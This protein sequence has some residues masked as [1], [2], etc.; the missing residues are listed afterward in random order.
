[1]E[2]KKILLPRTRFYNATDENLNIGLGLNESQILL[3]EGERNIVLDIDEIFNKERNDSNKYKIYGKIKMVF[4]N[5]YSGTTT[6]EPLLKFLYLTDSSNGYIPYNEFAF[7][8]NDVVREVNTNTEI[9]SLDDY[10]PII[11]LKGYDGHTT[12]TTI[13]APYKN[14]NIY[15]S[16]VFDQDNEYPLTYTL[17]GDTGGNKTFNFISSD[18]IPFRVV[19]NNKTF[20]LT[21]PVEHGMNVGEYV[22]I[23][24]TPLYI[25]SV[26]D[27]KYNSEK[28]VINI[29]ENDVPS[30]FNFNEVVFGKRCIDIDNRDIT[31]SKYY[32][33]KHKILTET[34][35]YIL[36]KIGFESP[37]WKDEKKILFENVLGENDIIVEKNRMESLIYDFKEPFILSGITNNLGY[38]PTDVYVTVIFRN[39]NG[40][41]EYPPKVGYNFNFHNTWI[42]NHFSGSTSNEVNLTES[43]IVT[44]TEGYTFKGG[45]ELKKDEILIGGF[46]EYNE[47]ELK[48]RLI[49]NSYHKLIHRSDIFDHGQ[50]SDEKIYGVS[51]DNKLGLF[52]QPHHKIKLRELSWYVDST[53]SEDVINL[54]E[55]T[56][57]Y[58]NE[59]IWRW[60]DLYE[61]GFIDPEGNG[62]NHPFI[63]GIHYVKNDIN[64]Y[65]RNE[66]FYINKE[67]EIKNI[68]RFDC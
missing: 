44:N 53:E 39:G 68:T 32:V 10:N 29:I 41:F 64:F 27:E 67:D 35:D 8:R 11:N 19:L 37:I 54:P 28:Y 55:N 51:P 38:T 23:N 40:Y 46:V 15:L 36:E 48:E 50:S 17:S 47:F 42:D 4:S 31:T 30:D 49:S 13:D 34:Q 25:S 33:H 61:H 43:L 66:E 3:R 9:E 60:R 52:Y 18:G 5:L 22:I 14:W 45:N 16:Y 2:K 20:K 56:K 57:Y 6:Y 7:L 24:E 62:V 26:G 21:S 1:M 58:E 59:G 65:L 12:I 63:N